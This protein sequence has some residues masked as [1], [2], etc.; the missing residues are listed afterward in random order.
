MKVLKLSFSWLD[1][2]ELFYYK[3]SDN[4][5]FPRISFDGFVA[6]AAQYG[7]NLANISSFS[8]FIIKNQTFW[9]IWKNEMFWFK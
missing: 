8:I 7:R 6:R 2:L 5:T 1:F 3:N 4:F 9:K